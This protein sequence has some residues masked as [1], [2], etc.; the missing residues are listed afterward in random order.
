M[1]GAANSGDLASV[2]SLLDHTANSSQDLKKFGLD[3]MEGSST[4]GHHPHPLAPSPLAPSPLVRVSSPSVRVSTSSDEADGHH[5]ETLD[6]KLDHHGSASDGGSIASSSPSIKKR[7]AYTDSPNSVSCPYCSRTFPWT[8]SLRRHILTHTGMKPFKCPKCPI[9]FT[10]KSNCE[11]HL[12][13]KHKY[14]SKSVHELVDGVMAKIASSGSNLNNGTNGCINGIN[15]S[16]NGI[17]NS[18]NSI[19]GINNS[20]NGINNSINGTNR[21][22]GKSKQYKCN[23]C[24]SFCST[25]SDLRKHYYLRHWTNGSSSSSPHPSNNR[26]LGHNTTNSTPSGLSKRKHL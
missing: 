11:R 15:S 3:S 12:I 18:I 26:N 7:S 25:Q 2:S 10:T 6:S 4:D 24:F 19:N 8:S 16:I 5:G 20:I 14:D 23:L 22:N 13:R 1:D 21:L 9:Y 17:N